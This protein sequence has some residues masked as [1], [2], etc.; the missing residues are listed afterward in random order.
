M[1][2]NPVGR[3]H[4]FKCGIKW[5]DRHVVEFLNN[6]T[7]NGIIHVFRGKSK[8][9]RITWGLIFLGVVIGCLTLIGFSIK[10]FVNKPTAT[11]II[12]QS[13]E[14]NEHFP[15]V[16][17][18]NVNPYYSKTDTL[19]NDLF[20]I[21]FNPVKEFYPLLQELNRSSVVELCNYYMENATDTSILTQE[22]WEYMLSVENPANF[23]QYCGYSE[24]D[25][26]ETFRRCEKEIVPVLT[27][28]GLCYTW[29]SIENEVN[30]LL[31]KNVGETYGLK[32]ILNIDQENRPGFGGEIGVKVIIHDWK[33]IARP[34]LYGI[35]VPTRKNAIIPIVKHSVVD[36]TE[37]VGCTDD[38]ELTFLSNVE[39]SRFACML[40]ATIKHIAETCSC[41]LGPVRPN[42]GPFVNIRNCTFND[43][44]CLYDASLNFDADCPLP[45]HYS[46]YDY[47][48]SYTSF[49]FRNVLFGLYGTNYSVDDTNYL[50]LHIFMENLHIINSITQYTYGLT[51]LFADFGGHSGLFL[52]ISIISIMEILILIIDEVKKICISKKVKAKIDAIDANLQVLDILDVEKGL[53]AEQIANEEAKNGILDVEKDLE[54]TYEEVSVNNKCDIESSD[55]H[56]N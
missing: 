11:T 43:S 40:D 44:C 29:N 20:Y 55:T 18:C 14:E 34:R 23:I 5:N 26:L 1:S 9:R 36:E 32:L 17:I 33:D 37:E 46:Y 12:Y 6:T 31:I 3:T 19:A 54:N 47:H 27:S 8:I 30:R 50:S 45:C 28:S 24:D 41:I 48:I 52:G 2:D 21:L 42:N 10:Q 53:N 56:S 25:S 51:N 35:N 7:I 39:Y 38:V 15:A 49:S 22:I 13:N 16:T 4:K